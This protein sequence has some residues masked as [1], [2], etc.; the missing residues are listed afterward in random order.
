[1]PDFL[2]NKKVIVAPLNWGLGHATRCIPVIDFLLQS[3]CEV[4]IA[5]DG[6]ALHFLKKQ[7]PNLSYLELPSYKVEYGKLNFTIQ[8]A[9]NFPDYLRA[10]INER[11][12]IEKYV[13]K[14]KVDFII[15]DNRYGCYNSNIPSAIICHQICMLVPKS[16]PWLR[17]SLYSVH[18]YFL[19]P[20][21]AI[22]V[23]DF[24]EEEFNIS[25]DMSHGI[26]LPLNTLFIGPLTR[27]ER[28]YNPEFDN[29]DI[30]VMLSGVEP[31][32]TILENKILEQA[33]AI[34]ERHFTFLKGVVDDTQTRHTDNI[35]ILPYL[36]G[37]GL[38]DLLINARLVI[39]RSGYSSVMDLYYLGKK[40]IFIPSKGQTEQE[41][42]AEISADRGW[43]I[44]QNENEL[45][46]K[47]AIAEV[48]KTVGLP[49]YNKN[50]I[51]LEKALKSLLS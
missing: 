41:Y 33:K 44:S 22:W 10:V 48:E 50:S 20:F 18:K 49:K 29:T 37:K 12:L 34:P 4:V 51:L 9:L 27:M 23:P 32:R 38:N 2:H 47:K 5:S 40:V 25:G 1:M 46:L 11:K 39:C 3:A 43:A 24:E 30:V 35:K 31:Q 17:P 19:K 8:T 16:T 36:S 42:L 28:N 7:Y 45:N 13:E 14:E 6:N 21:N 26:K 15:S